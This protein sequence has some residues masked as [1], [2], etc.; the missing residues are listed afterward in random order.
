MKCEFCEKTIP[1]GSVS[2]SY[3]GSLVR[4]AVSSTSHTVI[5]LEQ[6]KDIG[7]YKMSSD[8]K[9]PKAN[10]SDKEILYG[11]DMSHQKF[12]AQK[13]TSS[14]GYKPPIT[15]AGNAVI[16][17]GADGV[18]ERL[19][20]LENAVEDHRLEGVELQL[21]GLGRHGDRHIAADGVNPR[22]PETDV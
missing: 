4:N 9:S 15:N 7:N 17:Q 19:H 12:A 1:D 14:E 11:I 22:A 10:N 20:A 21:T 13:F 16:N 2:C 6:Q 5:S 3:C 8:Y 18:R